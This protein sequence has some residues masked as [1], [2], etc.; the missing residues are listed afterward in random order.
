MTGNVPSVRLQTE[1]FTELDGGAFAV[2]N[3]RLLILDYFERSHKLLGAP[4]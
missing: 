2:D 4:G 3:A 1:L